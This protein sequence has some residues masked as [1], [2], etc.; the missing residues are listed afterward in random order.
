VCESAPP[1][2]AQAGPKK[3][4]DSLSVPCDLCGERYG[5]HKADTNSCPDGNGTYMNARPCAHCGMSVTMHRGGVNCQ[6][7]KATYEPKV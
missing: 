2:P 7:S 6:G 1:A 5:N 3:F 4:T